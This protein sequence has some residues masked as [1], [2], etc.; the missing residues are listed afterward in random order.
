[1]TIRELDLENLK[2]LQKAGKIDKDE[3]LEKIADRL[4]EWRTWPLVDAKVK[5]AR[6]GRDSDL[7]KLMQKIDNENHRVR[8]AVA[9]RGRGHDLDKLVNDPDQYVRE[10]VARQG[11]NKDLDILVN[12]PAWSV[13][14]KVAD[15]G[16]DQDLDILVNDPAWPV[17]KKIL[18]DA[19]IEQLYRYYN[20]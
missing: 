13:R 10:A 17:L 1:M 9:N 18:N 4:P 16:R 3:D 19:E 8:A 14:Y 5:L 2:Q 20:I 12:D 6:Y 11:R 7:D 15:Q